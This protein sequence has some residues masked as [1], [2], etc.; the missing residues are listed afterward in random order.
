MLRG[1]W[2]ARLLR[3]NGC[4]S[5]DVV[6]LSDRHYN[7]AKGKA[8]YLTLAFQCI[9]DFNYGPQFGSWN[10]KEIV[11]VDR[12]VHLVINE[13]LNDVCWKYCTA[14]GRVEEDR[15]VHLI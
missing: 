12:N 15:G 2:V 7:C 5:R 3:L 11:K 13:W 8:G 10:D 4:G 9:T 1:R 14:E 6:F